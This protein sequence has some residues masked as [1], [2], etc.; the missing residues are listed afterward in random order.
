[1]TLIKLQS[2][3][4]AACMALFDGLS[5]RGFG[6]HVKA[7]RSPSLPRSLFFTVLLFVVP[8]TSPQFLSTEQRL[9]Q[10]T[11]FGLFTL[12]GPFQL[13]EHDIAAP[14]RWKRLHLLAEDRPEP[15]RHT[16]H[17]GPLHSPDIKH[18]VDHRRPLLAAS[19]GRH[20][21]GNAGPRSPRHGRPP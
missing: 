6:F 2:I 5:P 21:G 10:P 9:G 1:M 8:N 20:A 12:S 13:P 19:R 3:K 16:S 4:Q 7:W 18:N 15:L 11:G 17:S 14:H